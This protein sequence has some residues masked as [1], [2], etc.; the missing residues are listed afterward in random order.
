MP[1][2]PSVVWRRCSEE[3][4]VLDPV[5][6]NGLPQ[7]PDLVALRDQLDKHWSAE[8]AFWPEQWTPDRPSV[9]QCA[10]TS[11]LVFDRFGGDILRTVNQ[12][13][14][15]YW[16][17]IG[18]LDVDLT[19]DQFDLWAPEEQVATADRNHVEASGPTLADRYQRLIAALAG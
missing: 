17:R 4:S 5:I 7:G 14:P 1:A 13:V 19:R 6:P 8:T 12:G 2:D 3:R 11:L 9:G 15:H 18:G 10:V 16:N